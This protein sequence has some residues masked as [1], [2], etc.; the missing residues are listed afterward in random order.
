MNSLILILFKIVKYR[1]LQYERRYLAVNQW[2][3]CRQWIWF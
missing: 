2:N 1:K 3:L